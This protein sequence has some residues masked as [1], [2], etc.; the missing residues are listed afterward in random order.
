[1]VVVRF[2]SSPKIRF[3]WQSPNFLWRR[4][5]QHTKDLKQRRG[6]ED[7]HWIVRGRVAKHKVRGVKLNYKRKHVDWPGVE[8]SERRSWALR[9]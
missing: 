9:P 5:E 3:V 2:G 8:R 1:M 7:G 4:L 6:P